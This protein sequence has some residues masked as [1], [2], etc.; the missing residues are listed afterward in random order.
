MSNLLHTDTRRYER[1]FVLPITAV[2]QTLMQLHMHP[3]GM[4]EIYSKRAVRSC[5]YDT[6]SYTHLTENMAGVS[7]RRKVRIRWYG[8]SSST[9]RTQLEIKSKYGDVVDKSVHILPTL[10][11]HLLVKTPLQELLSSEHS[12]QL[13]L[14]I[15]HYRPVLQNSYQRRYFLSFDQQ[16]RVTLDTEL[17]FSYPTAIHTQ[18]NIYSLAILEYKYPQHAEQKVCELTQAFPFRLSKLSKYELGMRALYSELI[19]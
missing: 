1:K 3:M 13:P 2:E 19:A 15:Q 18:H 16:I 10:S 17:V 9:L 5:Y 12:V 11:A 6:P 7:P 4:R 8:G 14:P